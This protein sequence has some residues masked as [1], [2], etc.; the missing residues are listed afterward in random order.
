MLCQIASLKMLFALV[1]VL[2][3]VCY[4]VYYRRYVAGR[5]ELVCC[6]DKRKKLLEERCPILSQTYFPTIWTP[7]AHLQSVAR[8][9]LQT[10]PK[11]TRRR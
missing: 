1:V 9:L 7:L 8:P 5:P 2:L 10:S 6:D 3:L 4:V 11:H